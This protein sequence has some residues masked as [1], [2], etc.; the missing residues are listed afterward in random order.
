MEN[1]ELQ[2]IWK[3]IN[4]EID[5]KSKDELQLLLQSKAKQT[6]NKYVVIMGV[7]VTVSAGL[8]VYLITTTLNRPGDL[9]FLINNITLGIVAMIALISGSISWYKMQTNRFNQSL[10][11]WLNERISLLSQWL[12]GRLSKLYLFL[13]PFLYALIT[14]SIHVYFSNMS[15]LEVMKNGESVTGLLIAA[16]IGLFVSYYVARKIRR[17]QIQNL[18]F[19]KDMYDRLCKAD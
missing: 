15:F 3:S 5:S 10:K 2:Q 11:E 14:L 6:I 16:P 18:K 19:L 12:T 17:F 9:L 1:T 4:T 8:I 7:S 13:I